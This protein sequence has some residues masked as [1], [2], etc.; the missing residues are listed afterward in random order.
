MSCLRKELIKMVDNFLDILIFCIT[1]LSLLFII[2]FVVLWI[3][4]YIKSI[5]NKIANSQR[6]DTLMKLDCIIRYS[7]LSTN[8]NMV[9]RLKSSNMFTLLDKHEA[10]ELT[11]SR[12]EKNIDL[13]NCKTCLFYI[14]DLDEWINNRI[15]YYVQHNK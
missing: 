10:F 15:E 12:I 11:K 7:V 1:V 2:F 14:N 4:T 13:E 8:F 5:D 9:N 6:K 3:K